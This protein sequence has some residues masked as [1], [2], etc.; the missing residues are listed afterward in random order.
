VPGRSGE[1][2][3]RNPKREAF[4]LRGSKKERKGMTWVG[5]GKRRSLASFSSCGLG[6][7]G[8]RHRWTV[9]DAPVDSPRGARTVRPPSVDGPLLL[10]ERPELHLFSTSREDGPHRPGGQS[11]R[12]GRTVWPIATDGPTSLFNFSLI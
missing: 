1:C 9:R 7:T 4:S 10:P 11:A 8:A 2:S 5:L 12:S 3:N 6:P